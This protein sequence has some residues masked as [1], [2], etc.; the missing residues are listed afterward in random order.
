MPLRHWYN[1]GTKHFHQTSVVWWKW[2]TQLGWV[3]KPVPHDLVRR[4]RFWRIKSPE[5]DFKY[6]YWTISQVLFWNISTCKGTYIYRLIGI[7]W[8]GRA[9]L[10]LSMYLCVYIYVYMYTYIDICIC[11]YVYI[12]I[13][14]S[15]IYVYIYIFLSQIAGC[16]LSLS[17]YVFVSIYICIHV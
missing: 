14:L 17:L 12:Y 11:I 4:I 5:Q 13:C 1:C 15:Q 9:G 16:S 8:L 10:A 3:I 2:K 6:L 7:D